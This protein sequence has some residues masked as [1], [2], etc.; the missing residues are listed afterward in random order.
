[1]ILQ[2]I[3][4]VWGLS[5]LTFS[6][7][8]QTMSE[9]EYQTYINK[10]FYEIWP[11]CE[12][13]KDQECIFNHTD[14][15]ISI[16]KAL[17]DWPAVIYFIEWKSHY[18]DRFSRRDLY[19]ASLRDA[20]H[21]LTEY[22]DSLGELFHEYHVSNALRWGKYY[23]DRG[24]W[25]RALETYNN[26]NAWLL[27]RTSKTQEDLSAIS[28]AFTSMGVIHR[29]Q[30]A[31]DLA[32]DYFQKGIDFEKQKGA[33]ARQSGFIAIADKHIGDLYLKKGQHA[34]ALK[35]YHQARAVYEQ[36]D[37]SQ[38]FLR[39]GLST[40][41]VGIANVHKAM[42]DSR[43]S[44]SALK[45]ALTTDGYGSI[46]YHIWFYLGEHYTQSGDISAAFHCFDRAFERRIAKFGLQHYKVAEVYQAWGDLELRRDD[47]ACALEHYQAALICLLDDFQDT[48]IRSNPLSFRR[49]FIR[50]EILGLL[51][52]K[53][54]ALRR[55]A[56]KSGNMAHLH[57]AW[58]TI[59]AAV[60]AMDVLY[61]GDLK[62]E[63]DKLLLFQQSSKIIELGVQIAWQL[64]PEFHALAFELSEKGKAIILLEAYRNSNALQLAGIS[65]SL[66][67][68]EAQL[69]YEISEAEDA[70][71]RGDKS[72]ALKDRLF[73][74]RNEYRD[75][76]RSIEKKYPDYYRLR[77][78]RKVADV[79]QV[80][81]SLRRGQAMVSYF[82]GDSSR[83][84][85]VIQS[86]GLAMYPLATKE[87]LEP[88]V[89]ALRNSIYGYFLS[90]QRTEAAY[91]ENA[92]QY[93]HHARRLYEILWQPFAASLPEEVLVVPDGVLGYLPFDVLLTAAPQGSAISFKTHPYLL[94]RH[95]IGYCYSA[96]LWKEMQ[97]NATNN[98]QLAAFA[99][100]FPGIDR[101]KK[102]IAMRGGL[103]TLYYNQ[104]EVRA[105]AS[106]LKTSGVFTGKDAIKSTFLQQSKHA[107]ILHIASHGIA[108]DTASGYSFIAFTSSHAHP[109]SSRL[110]ARELYNLRLNAAM[111]VLSACETGVGELKKG[112]GVVSLAR[113]FAY[114]G[115]QSV[116][117]TLW[118]VNDASTT[119]IM[120]EMYKQ[121]RAGAGKSE[122]LQTSKISFLERGADDLAAHPY[123][124]S[125][126]IA[127]GDMQP[128]YG[129]RLT[130]LL[131]IA[132][133]LMAILGAIAGVKWKKSSAGK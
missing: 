70:V 69:K 106:V 27:G 7:A 34:A 81:N 41:W 62:S 104:P 115:A 68:R 77:Y 63:E 111:V 52:G 64:G 80:Q 92:G 51:A 55:L 15:L 58:A 28:N 19:Y 132:V 122:A 131:M 2:R 108:N 36:A 35:Y 99:P 22:Q 20:E 114:A 101:P 89:S 56:S 61:A 98:K 121:L 93:V 86:K 130:F 125:A 75:L 30:G 91:V 24:D 103:D 102:Q 59:N 17:K 53:T 73:N 16:G 65:D 90:D 124:W 82:N 72:P 96:T 118:S 119:S 44:L 39:N 46:D 110:Y 107:G 117:S 85:F 79:L 37:T 126:Y 9:A 6:A 71:F 87:P 23:F 29:D 4:S 31:Y 12:Q 3:L 45:T 8:A 84:A 11:A 40:T 78:D 105:I 109:D 5:L 74:T 33:A 76:L 83:F 66:L 128:L 13:R 48:D 42:N 127:I 60:N 50:Q 32:L 14:Q 95:Q 120:Q 1:M 97:Q 43:A 54:E 123:Y 94:H 88:L 49:T 26:I 25:P 21:F 47:P 129:R 18:S 10:V 112:E 116:I 57:T 113:A 38:D 100:S 67:E 133:L